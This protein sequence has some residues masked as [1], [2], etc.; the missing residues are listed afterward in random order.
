[1]K[2]AE[3]KRYERIVNVPQKLSVSVELNECLA[4]RNCQGMVTYE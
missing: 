1:M 2:K 3:S 4:N